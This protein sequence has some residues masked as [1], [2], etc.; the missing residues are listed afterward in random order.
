MFS[1]LY[2]KRAFNESDEPLVV[3][4]SENVQLH[5]FSG[6][7]YYEPK[8]PCDP[9]QISRFRHVPGEA[10]VEQLLKATIEAA[11]SMGPVKKSEFERLTVDTTVQEKAV[12]FP[13]DSRLLEVAC[14]K[15][16]CPPPPVYKRLKRVSRRQRTIL[17]SLLREVGRRMT[18]LTQDPRAVAAQ[19]S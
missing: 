14:E 10:G 13:T 12:A 18:E 17:G 2:L 16:V 7:A 8:L 9:V 11:V 19:H 3:R 15:I 1:L 5:F 4:W 6:I